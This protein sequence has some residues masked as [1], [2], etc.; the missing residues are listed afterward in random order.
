M[1]FRIVLTVDVCKATMKDTNP[2]AEDLEQFV[3]DELGW[4]QQS[5]DDMNIKSIEKI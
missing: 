2:D 1:K 4:A 5:F 3:Q